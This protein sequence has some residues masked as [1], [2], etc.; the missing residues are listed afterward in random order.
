VVGVNRY[1]EGEIAAPAF[2]H[3]PAVERR[4]AKFLAEW[5]AEREAKAVERAVKRLGSEAGGTGNLM[6][7]ILEALKVG[8]TLGEVCDTLRTEFGSYRPTG[9][10]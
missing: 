10:R 4:R 8:V 3:D 6:P 1:V 2:R 7:A 9:E 5:R